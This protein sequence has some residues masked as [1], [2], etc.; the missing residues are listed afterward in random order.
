MSNSAQASALLSKGNQLRQQGKHNEAYQALKKAFEYYQAAKDRVG[1][2]NAVL[3]IGY[4][5]RSIGK[6][7]EARKSY[8][9]TLQAYRKLNNAQG[10]ANAL[11]AI[12]DLE[13]A[14]P[15]GNEATARRSYLEAM[16][17]YQA[18]NDRI[19]K[20]NVLRGL[21]DLEIK[22]GR[23]EE[24]HKSLSNA[25]DLY[26]KYQSG[27]VGEAN[28][29]IGLADLSEKMGNID[30]SRSCYLRAMELGRALS[31][32]FAISQGQAG[33][34]RLSERELFLA[35]HG[36]AQKD[37]DT[38]V[39]PVEKLEHRF[40]RIYGADRLARM[41]KM[42]SAAYRKALL[43]YLPK[44]REWSVVLM[45]DIR[46][47]TTAMARMDPE[48]Q[49]AFLDTY[50]SRGTAL[51]QKHHG[52][53][54]KYMGD[55][56]LAFFRPDDEFPADVTVKNA[57]NAALD[58][59][60]DSTINNLFKESRSHYAD[61]DETDFGVGVGLAAGIAKFGEIGDKYR[62]EYTLIGRAVNLAS[63][64]QS[65]SIAGEVLCTRECWNKFSLES[66]TCENLEAALCSA[67][68][69]AGRMK[70]YENDALVKITRT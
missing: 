62:E 18:N 27:G 16:P 20:A 68:Q 44:T 19:G 23:L 15:G 14:A 47:Y 17:I 66:L 24:A 50:L 69:T 32:N 28:T 8:L 10:E 29:L 25:L 2:A 21:A 22:A 58:I 41:A 67:D 36:Q 40:R 60:S 57:L 30:Y 63:R 43:S 55:A 49:V 70:G 3:S 12:A 4:L 6:F 33:L 52:G 34:A 54:D 48:M 13:S 42:D 5:Q 7:N 64:V 51:I 61:L 56:I 26:R 35:S 65:L 59:V 37:E 46:G 39:E 38:Q 1:E 9:D 45:C 53:V 11:T 31:Y